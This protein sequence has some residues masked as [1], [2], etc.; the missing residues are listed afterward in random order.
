MG[1]ILFDSTDFTVALGHP[2]H[3]GYSEG[4]DVIAILKKSYCRLNS[5]YSFNSWKSLPGNIELWV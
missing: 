3:S 2:G 4:Q 5:K 1:F